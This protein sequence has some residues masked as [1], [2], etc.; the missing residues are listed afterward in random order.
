MLSGL[1]VS[2]ERLLPKT[3]SLYDKKILIFRFELI[4]R[5]LSISRKLGGLIIGYNWL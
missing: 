1:K 3:D 2:L 4:A 5:F